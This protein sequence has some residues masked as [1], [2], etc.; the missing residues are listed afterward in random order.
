MNP[1]RNIFR[2][3]VG[4][5]VA[6]SLN[7]LAFVYL[8]RTLGVEGYGVLEFALAILTYFLL[9]ADGGLELWATREVASGTDL[10]S[11][12]ARIVPLRFVLALASFCGL[13]GFLLVL[14]NY[15]GLRT[16]M[17][18]FG[19]TLFTQAVNL[20]WVFMGREEMPRVAIGLIIAQ[21]V[22][23]V[24]ILVLVR[25]PR[26]IL[27]VPVLRLTSDL[28][29]A[30][31]FGRLFVKLNGDLRLRF[32]LRK[33]GMALRSALPLGASHGLAFM[34]YNFDT[35]LLGLLLT[36]AAVGLYSAA[37]KPV[38]VV[39]AMPTTYFIGLFPTLARTYTQDRDSFSAIANRSFGLAALCAVPLGI[40]GLFLASPI[41]NFLFGP[42]YTSAVPVLQ[43]LVWSA[44]LVILRGTFRQS[45]NGAGRAGLDLRCA[46]ASVLLNITLNLLLI[47]RYG[48]IGAAVATLVSE[49]LWFS[50]AYYYFNRY[51]SRLKLLP[52]LHQPVMA[53]I[54]MG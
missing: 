2:L 33:A 42:A 32:T 53:A 19:L 10:R 54:V 38:T 6:K 15:P 49:V 17:I 20:K 46:G 25:S 51:I 13:I 43:I 35:I 50:L 9:F 23:A 48:I 45:L 8:A 1:F 3:S 39:L 11:L 4:D 40:G 52:L 41:I 29:M 14:P 34:S 18:L 22:F 31:Y 28:A 37:Y 27:W 44:A 30:V 47:P 16:V 36:P 24:A 26:T 7:F 21:V 12:A 5:F